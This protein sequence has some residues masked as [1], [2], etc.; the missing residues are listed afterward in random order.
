MKKLSKI[1]AR[2]EFR[3]FHRV[4]MSDRTD[5]RSLVGG[6]TCHDVPGNFN[7]EDGIL[8]RFELTCLLLLL[9]P[10]LMRLKVSTLR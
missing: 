5:G 6:Y 2:K 7:W 3:R 1:S 9:K 4:Y 8:T 10:F